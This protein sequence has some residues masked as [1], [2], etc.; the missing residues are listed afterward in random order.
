[1]FP[2]GDSLK[3]AVI[4]MTA[5]SQSTDVFTAQYFRTN[6]TAAGYDTALHAASLTSISGRE[7]WMLDR[8]NGSSNVR[9]TLNY[10]S[11][12][13]IPVASLYSLRISRWNGSQWLNNGASSVTGSLAEAFVTSLDTLSAFGPI[14]LGYVL[15]ARIPI[16]TAVSYTHLDVYKRQV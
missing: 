7:Y 3:Q 15:P 2:T 13:S 14:T 5:P 12:R 16:I 9:I 4:K 11:T 6:P 10:D 8:E 1:M